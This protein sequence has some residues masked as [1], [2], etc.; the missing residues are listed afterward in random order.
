MHAAPSD[1]P[2]PRDG[3]SDA[4]PAPSLTRDGWR[5]LLPVGALAIAHLAAPHVRMGELAASLVTFALGTVVSLGGLTLTAPRKARPRESAA[6][7]LIAALGLAAVAWRIAPPS[8]A[9]L[10]TATAHL[11][12]ASALGAS[13]GHRV[14][15]PGHLLPAC[16]VAAAADLASITTPGMPT[17]ELLTTERALDLVAFPAPVPG[18]SSW[19]PVIGIGDLV[20]AALV[21]GAAAAHSLSRARASTALVLGALLAGVA[22]AALERPVPALVP[23]AASVVALLPAVRRPR[24]RD[25]RATQLALA[26]AAAVIAA[27]VVKRL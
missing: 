16:A 5:F 3:A 24:P 18:T 8:L 12:L 15:H 27:V 26:L 1:T 14:E 9:G 4:A 23:M 11:L 20:F 21:L 10:A 17:R 25:R 22:S 7:A 13:I 19:A 2:P 6:L